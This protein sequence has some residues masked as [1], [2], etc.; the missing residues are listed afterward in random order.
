[1]LA[2]VCVPPQRDRAGT[3]LV[4]RPRPSLVSAPDRLFGREKR[5]VRVVGGL[6]SLDGAGSLV[7]IG[8]DEGKDGAV[9]SGGVIVQHC[10]DLHRENES[11]GAG[12]I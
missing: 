4:N 11:A 9:E 1:M 2:I 5:E 8:V 12:L 7:V 3:A 6:F 10:W